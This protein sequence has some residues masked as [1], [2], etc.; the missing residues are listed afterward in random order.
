MSDDAGNFLYKK[1][2]ILAGSTGGKKR[3]DDRGNRLPRRCAPR[4]DSDNTTGVAGLDPRRRE[5][6]TGNAGGNKRA[7]LFTWKL[8][9]PCWI[10]D[11]LFLCNSHRAGGVVTPRF[12]G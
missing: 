10:L 12:V 7:K 3:E 2:W 1:T 9:V 11:I 4:N 6:D 5:D 8:D